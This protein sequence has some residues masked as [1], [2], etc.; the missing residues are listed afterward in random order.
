LTTVTGVNVP[1]IYHTD[2]HDTVIRKYAETVQ[3]NNPDKYQVR[4]ILDEE[5]ITEIGGIKPDLI[6]YSP[7]T[8]E[9]VLVIEV[10]TLETLSESQ[11]E[12][13]WLPLSKSTKSLQIIIPKGTLVRA[14]GF[15]RKLGI[16]AG[17]QEY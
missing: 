15:C 13:R 2:D 10:E 12:E 7:N 9:P 16:K 3:K 17:F 4:M 8:Q 6:L 1:K 5:E 11:A 14:R